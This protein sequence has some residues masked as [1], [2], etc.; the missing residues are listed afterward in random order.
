MLDTAVFTDAP[1]DTEFGT[2]KATN[3]ALAATP[4]AALAATA[5]LAAAVAAYAVEETVGN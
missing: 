3:A 1:F 2:V 4:L 5:V